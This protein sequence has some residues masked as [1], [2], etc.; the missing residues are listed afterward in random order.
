MTGKKQF[1]RG[2]DIPGR[3]GADVLSVADGVVTRSEKNGSFGWMV[4]IDHGDGYTTLYSHN[5]ENL[6]EVGATVTKGQAIA[7]IGSTGRSTGP[8]VHFEVAKNKRTINPV[9]YL[10]KKT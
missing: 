1:H 9:R 2:V 8:H 10:Y 6:V 5:K 3:E 7:R 4:E